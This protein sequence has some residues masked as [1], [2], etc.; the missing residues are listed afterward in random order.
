[1]EFRAA[2]DIDRSAADA[3]WGLARAFE[4]LGQYYETVEELKTVAD[5]APENLEAKTKLGNY[6][7]LGQPPQIAETERL[8]EDVFARDANF[9]EGYILKAGLFAAQKKSEKEVL[10]V[11]NQAVALN[12]N[13]TESY[14]A[15]ARYYAKINR[16]QDAE[17]A[18][19]KGIAANQNHALGYL[20]YGRFLAFGDRAAQAETQFKKAVEV[21]PSNI[22]ARESLAEFYLDQRQLDRAENEYKKLVEIQ[23]NSPE[24]RLD[25]G[26]FYAGVGREDDA[27]A[28]FG[29]I[30]AEKSE[31]ARARYRLGEI[32]LD[33]KDNQKVIE[34]TEELLK[35]NGDDAEALML[36]ARVRLQENKPE[37][38][39]KDL[40]EILKKQPSQKNALFYMTNARL[41]LGQIDQAR[42][43]IG[44]LEKYHPNFLKTK[45][46][47]IQASFS[48]GDSD[49]ALRQA[50]ELLDAVKN[51]YPSA[52]ND[53][54]N[55][56]DLRVRALTARGLAFL[57]VGKTAEARADLQSVQT[58][59]PNS[60]AALVNL[61]KVAVAERNL[62]EA[63]GLYERALAAD[64][65]NFDALSGLTNVLTKQ[66][67]FDAAHAKIGKAIEANQSQKDVLPAL[68]YLNANVFT[69]QRNGEAAEAELKRAI[70]IDDEYLPAYSSYA[71]I[72]IER[73]QTDE[74]VAQYKK[75]V[76]RKPSAA[77]YTLIGMLEDARNNSAEAETNYRRALEIA[78]DAPIA[79]NNLAWLLAA[80][81]GNLDEA[82]TLAQTVVGKN[83]NVAGYYD[84]LGWVYFRKELFSPAVEQMKKAVALDEASAARS[85]ERPNSA[86]RLRLGMALASAG[87]RFSAK[88]EV[89]IS[90]QNGKNLSDKEAQDARNLLASL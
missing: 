9:V 10:D 20:E 52:E 19:Q 90:L 39:V 55:L 25:L 33:R 11:L 59:S 30:V 7:L 75:I 31:Y 70:E 68:H 63:A 45:L 42:A 27:I 51:A 12:P 26:N 49:A 37:E 3:H 82:L 48:L 34:Q 83:A 50:N 41:A 72:L 84:T 66:K 57:E 44:D 36:R 56:E 60:S 53:A 23:E 8:V 4:N 81:G 73:N 40:E 5:L 35:L 6:Y 85:G 28:V 77:I 86:Y 54:Q 46:L 69:A 61:A 80:N 87:D 88:R 1:M 24:S 76:E 79:A 38:A 58:L 15:L 47:K 74:A 43:F 22:E 21:E 71:A 64:Q 32:Y 16:P 89:E 78:P 14:L 17:Q 65:K 18:I 67:Q 13:R 2:S 29:A 62:S